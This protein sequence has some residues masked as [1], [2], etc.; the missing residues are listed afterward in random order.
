[1]SRMYF[2]VAMVMLIMTCSPVLARDGW[3]ESIAAAHAIEMHAEYSCFH[4][5]DVWCHI[6][7]HSWCGTSCKVSGYGVAV[8]TATSPSHSDVKIHR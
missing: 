3:R 5:R 1:V 2:H 7:T 6:G 8:H 4:P